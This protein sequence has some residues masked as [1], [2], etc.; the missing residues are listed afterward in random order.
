MFM[1]E[2][3]KKFTSIA[4]IE[5]ERKMVIYVRESSKAQ[6]KDGYNMHTQELKCM[7]YIKAVFDESDAS[8]VEVYREMGYS[9]KTINRPKLDVLLDEI[10]GGRV[11]CVIVQRL[12]RLARR[13]LGMQQLLSL[14]IEY[15]VRLITLREC[16][17]TNSPFCKVAIAMNILFAEIEQ[18]NIS[19]RTND[20]LE[21]AVNIGNYVKGG[22]AP[23]GT[24]REKK[25]KGNDHH[26]VFLKPDP[27]FWSVLEKIYDL[28]YHGNNCAIITAYVNEMPVMKENGQSLSEDAVEKI[29]G[30]KIYCGYQKFKGEL[31]KV[32]FDGC[33]DTKYWEQVQINRSIHFKRDTK[34]EYLYH[35][36]VH[37][38]CGTICVVDVAKKKLADGSYKRYK[39]YVC[40]KCGKRISET[41]VYDKAENELKKFYDTNVSDKY[42]TSQMDRLKKIESLDDTF[43]QLYIQGVLSL[44]ELKKK[45]QQTQLTK[46]RIE[47]NM[48]RSIKDYGKLTSVERKEFINSNVKNII[49]R[50]NRV[51]I[52]YI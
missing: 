25:Y 17:D 48:L 21:Y 14:F 8:N 27:T 51:E 28:A 20:A 19:E 29:L 18:D 35:H 5:D 41:F 31:Y 38:E 33:L 15:K 12:D 47:K 11:K 36:K 42:K 1:K 23:F 49:I 52:N 16:I 7:N 30:N 6:V 2:K 22:K 39:Y 46:K 26:S 40:P 10:K 3:M 34:L 44:K 45:M 37:C 4:D 50:N 9:A 43:Y 32:N 13:T 24:T